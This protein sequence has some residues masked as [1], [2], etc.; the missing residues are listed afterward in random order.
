MSH[1]RHCGFASQP[2]QLQRNQ[3]AKK[4]KCF[5]EHW[6]HVRFFPTV[7]VFRYGWNDKTL[8]CLNLG[9]RQNAF[10]MLSPITWFRF[11]TL[12]LLLSS[13]HLAAHD[14]SL[15]LLKVVTASV[16]THAGYHLL[17]SPLAAAKPAALC[18]YKA[19]YRRH[20]YLF[21]DSGMLW[22]FPCW[23]WEVCHLIVPAHKKQCNLNPGG[24]NVML[25]L[26]YS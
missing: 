17:L 12:P 6:E 22:R 8:L 3:S 11:Q 14:M 16:I 19:E 20:F 23:M 10:E 5:R 2:R 25:I 26:R 13:Y 15:V 4:K 18:V 1:V 9:A 7:T 21:S 24:M